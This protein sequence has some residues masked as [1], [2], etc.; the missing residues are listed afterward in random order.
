MAREQT[1]IERWNQVALVLERRNPTVFRT[2]LELG[3]LA[4][5]NIAKE[6]RVAESRKG[7]QS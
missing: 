6:D 4:A 3:E 7:G 2:L 1:A 5:A